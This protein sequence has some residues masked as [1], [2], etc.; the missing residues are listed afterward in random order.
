MREVRRLAGAR[1]AA[2]ARPARRIRPGATSRSAASAAFAPIDLLRVGR[3]AATGPEARAYVGREADG[4]CALLCAPRARDR[5]GG[6]A[7]QRRRLPR[8]LS[9]MVSSSRCA[10]DRAL[11]ERGGQRPRRGADRLR[12]LRAPSASACRRCPEGMEIRASAHRGGVVGGGV[13][14]AGRAACGRCTGARREP[15]AAMAGN[16]YKCDE[17]IHPHFGSWNPVVCAE[18]G[19][20]PAGVLRRAGDGKYGQ[21]VNFAPAP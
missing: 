21:G 1:G 18:A 9:G 2:G 5:R 15:G 17:S 4:F 7:V 3:D 11:S 19:L 13:P 6:D 16:F 14:R 8:Q 10:D 20:P 12:A